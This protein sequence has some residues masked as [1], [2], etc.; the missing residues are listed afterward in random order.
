MVESERNIYWHLMKRTPSVTG[1]RVE[2]VCVEEERGVSER[3]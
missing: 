2:T 3:S 1:E